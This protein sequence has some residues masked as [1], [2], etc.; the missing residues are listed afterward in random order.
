MLKPSSCGKVMAHFLSRKRII[1]VVVDVEDE[2]L[3]HPPP[4]SER[5]K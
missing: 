2:N 5:Q 1:A 4:N 3:I